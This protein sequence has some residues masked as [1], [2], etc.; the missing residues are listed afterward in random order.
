M[1]LAS[2]AVGVCIPLQWRN[3]PRFSRGSRSLAATIGCLKHPTLSKN[4]FCGRA[5]FANCQEEFSDFFGR[6]RSFEY[7]HGERCCYDGSAPSGKSYEFAEQNECRGAARVA[8]RANREE[9]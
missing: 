5:S 7:C 9:S 3:R 6:A 8:P 4:C 2:V 1:R